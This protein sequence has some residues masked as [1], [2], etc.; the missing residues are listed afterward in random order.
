MAV[1]VEGISVVI[2]CDAIRDRHVGSLKAFM[3][4]LPNESFCADGELARV[5]FMS[6]SDA[7]AYVEHLGRRG[8]CYAVD[9]I[10]KDLV[11]VD[12]RTGMR[13]NCTWA[14]FGS[15]D[16]EKDPK[17]PIVVCAA[18]PTHVDGV[19]VPRG[20]IFERSLSARHRYVESSRMGE[21]KFLRHEGGVDVYV[22]PATGD[23]HYVGRSM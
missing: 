3:A 12:Q 16:W 9:G 20:W 17:R 1:I 21:M 15:T 18:L 22:D 5:G 19:V 23:E 11:V 10:A 6:P 7:K 14:L 8:L 13:A 2:R 4:E